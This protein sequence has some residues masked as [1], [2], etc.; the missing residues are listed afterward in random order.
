MEREIGLEQRA[1]GERQT[2]GTVE[3][4]PVDSHPLPPAKL[5]RPTY[6]PATMALG[7]AFI[8]WGL[9]TTYI[10][11]GAGFVLFIVALAGWIGELLHEER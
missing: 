10:I 6:W 4:P 2:H 5:P 3:R 1:T 8:F 9:V 7:I 11:S